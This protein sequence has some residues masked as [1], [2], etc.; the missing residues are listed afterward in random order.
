M[1]ITAKAPCKV[2]ITGEHGVV[3]GSPA[4]AMAIEPFNTVTLTTE[5]GSPCIV[6]QIK[7]KQVTLDKNGEVIAGA[8]S[9]EEIAAVAAIIAKKKTVNVA[10]AQEAL[11]QR[12][13]LKLKKVT[14]KVVN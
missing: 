13:E 4:L 7:G 8:S 6:L 14:K 5:A 12:K 9:E 1:K 3:H 2:I 10:S 11:K